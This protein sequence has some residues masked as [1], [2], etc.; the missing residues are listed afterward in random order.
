MH[1]APRRI[2]NWNLDGPPRRIPILNLTKSAMNMKSSL[3]EYT[4]RQSSHN[5]GFL[6]VVAMEGLYYWSNVR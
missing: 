1:S 4:V 2:L 6:L 3:T 5:K